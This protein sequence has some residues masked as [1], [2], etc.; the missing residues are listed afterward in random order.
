M[1]K[2]L[3]LAANPAGTTR[4]AVDEELRAIDARIRSAAHRDHLQLI[5]HWA[6]RLDELSGLL[7]RERPDIV[8]FS[9][10]GSKSGRI[11]LT[12]ADRKRRPVSAASLAERFRILR[13]NIRVVV[14]NAC[15]STVQAREIV[16]SID[17][18]LGMSDEIVNDRAID[19]A[20][21][22]YEALAYG[23]SI[24]E[25]FDLGVLRLKEEGAAKGLAK[26]HKRRGV[27]LSR[28]E[29]IQARVGANHERRGERVP[30]SPRPVAME[31]PGRATSEGQLPLVFI[32]YSHKDRTWLDRLRVHL[33][34]LERQR[35]I[36]TWDDTRLRSGMRW[37]DQI[38]AALASASVAVLLV[39]PDFLASD[40]ITNDELPP[41]LAAEEARGLVVMPVI[42]SPSRFSRTPSLAQFN[43]VNPDLKPLLDMTEGERDALW[44]R[45]VNDIEATIAKAEE[46]ERARAKKAGPALAEGPR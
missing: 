36:E 31:T 15:Y 39:S 2:V 6:V 13:D 30:L 12:G 46:E 32:S 22:F 26:L 24:Q 11:V 1:I 9:G 3:F 45:L 43:A 7:M 37:H 19:F 41:L 20:A 16:K 34:P 33:K 40:F 25:A 4:L 14:L 44:N 28:L 8:H 18:A 29:L 17:C 42:I 38:K 21:A 27:D 5:S 23:R 35:V 10:H